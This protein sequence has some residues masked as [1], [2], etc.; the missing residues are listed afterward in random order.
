MTMKRKFS[1]NCKPA[2]LFPLVAQHYEFCTSLS[3]NS[4]TYDIVVVKPCELRYYNS[5]ESVVHGII[6]KQHLSQTMGEFA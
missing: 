6:S 4:L 5:S 2:L 3:S 1:K